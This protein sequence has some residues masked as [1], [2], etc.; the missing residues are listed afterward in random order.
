MSDILRLYHWSPRERQE[1]IFNSGLLPY[2]EDIDGSEYR[3]PCVCLSPTPAQ[4]WRY[5]YG[6]WGTKGTFDLW[7]VFVS[8]EDKVEVITV[9]S[10]EVVEVR[11]HN[12]IDLARL[13]LVAEK[14]T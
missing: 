2:Q 10:G 13:I 5:S 9:K 4:A 3:Q 6:T 1:S 11:I 12:Q 7:E 14:T 8:P